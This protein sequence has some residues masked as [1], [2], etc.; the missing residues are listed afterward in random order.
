MKR[1]IL[2]FFKPVALWWNS[3]QY[4]ALEDEIQMRNAM[5]LRVAV[6]R[7]GPEAGYYSACYVRLNTEIYQ[8]RLRQ[9]KLREQ[10]VQ[11]HQR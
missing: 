4:A 10:R 7:H 5:Q 8:L 6:G 1:A 11:I 2:R 9:R 3:F